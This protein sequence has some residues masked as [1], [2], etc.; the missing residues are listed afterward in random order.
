[1]DALSSV[2][3]STLGCA[4]SIGFE[5]SCIGST[6]GELSVCGS[7]IEAGTSGSRID[8]VFLTEACDC[9]RSSA[10]LSARDTCWTVF[11]SVV[12][13]SSLA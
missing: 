1:M 7:G 2:F 11:V 4:S 3:S 5:I 13:F 8:S 6:S 12:E 9:F 10:S